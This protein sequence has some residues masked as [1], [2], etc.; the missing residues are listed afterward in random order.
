MYRI[1]F[2]GTKKMP[3]KALTKSFSSYEK[4]RQALRKFLRTNRYSA[5]KAFT[6][7]DKS[8][9]NFTVLG[10]SIRRFPSSL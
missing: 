8:N 1:L 9:A 3:A 10:F 4:A 5:K 6:N 7:Q 2:K